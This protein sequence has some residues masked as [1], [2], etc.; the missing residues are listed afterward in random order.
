MALGVT[1]ERISYGNTIK[2]ARDIQSGEGEDCVIA[3][4]TC[5]S[6]DIMYEHHKYPLP[7]ILAIGDR[8]YWLSTGAYTP[9]TPRPGT[10]LTNSTR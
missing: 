3:G 5:D 4:P 9:P 10:E 7:L 2:K 1:G 8:M 6:A